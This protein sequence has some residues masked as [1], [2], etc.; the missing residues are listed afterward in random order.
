MVCCLF[1]QPGTDCCE[2]KYCYFALGFVWQISQD[3][4]QR[5]IQQ[6][7]RFKCAICAALNKPR[8][9]K[10]EEQHASLCWIDSSK[11]TEYIRIAE[12]GTISEAYCRTKRFVRAQ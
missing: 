12:Q 10:R 3:R 8:L 2:K 7:S 1:V 5:L 11:I 9:F 4:F 6:H